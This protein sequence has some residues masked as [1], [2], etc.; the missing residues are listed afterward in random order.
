MVTREACVADYLKRLLPVA[1]NKA[2]CDLA[3]RAL[4]LEDMRERRRIQWQETMV[5]G[6]P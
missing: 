3:I 4:D 5:D 2:I 1:G 6:E